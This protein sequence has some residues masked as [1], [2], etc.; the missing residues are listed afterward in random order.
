LQG[1]FIFASSEIIH[2]YFN[3][4]DLTTPIR[5]V[6][7]GEEFFQALESLIHSA[8][9]EIHLQTYRF[10]DDQAGRGAWAALQM[11]ANKGVKIY[12]L[13][14]AYGSGTLSKTFIQQAKDAGIHL[15]FFSPLFS[16]KGWF[17]GR[18]LH[19]KI[20][21]ADGERALIGGINISERY[22]GDETEPAW[23]DFALWLEGEICQKVQSIC[24]ELWGKKLL[25]P[26]KLI[27]RKQAPGQKVKGLTSIIHNDWFRYKNQVD[28]RYRQSVRKAKDSIL[29]VA[30]YFLPGNRFRH[31]LEMAARRGVSIRLI[32]AGRSDVPMLQF[33]GTHLYKYLLKKGIE[34]YEWD[35]SVLHAK[36]MIIDGSWC[37]LGSFNLNYLS[38]YGSIETN[39]ESSEPELVRE[40]GARLDD[41]L[42]RCTPITLEDFEKKAGWWVRCRNWVSYRLMRRAFLIMTFFTFKRW[43]QTT[44]RE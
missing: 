19:H 24:T 25:P 4:T 21:V 32:L 6:Q 43:G 12:L 37:T 26:I 17:F 41:V 5:L 40:L 36:V 2:P 13:F 29:I 3:Q 42:A 7:S 14:D 23:L 18:R 39:V 28:D 30:S 22:L 1:F 33:A 31:A 10:A 38:T 27:G 9:D 16:F 8:K 35:A 44:F 20:V 15:R 11:A 34:I